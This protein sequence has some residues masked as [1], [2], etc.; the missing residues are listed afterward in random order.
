MI[1]RVTGG[2]LFDR[3][4]QKGMYTERDASNVVKQLLNAV[5]YIH[6]L[7]IIHRDLKPENLLYFE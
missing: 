5:E 1:S 7:S 3:I 6:S 2:E 4:V